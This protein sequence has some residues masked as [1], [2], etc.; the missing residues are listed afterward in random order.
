MRHV[1]FVLWFPVALLIFAFLTEALSAV[2]DS[3]GISDFQATS[4]LIFIVSAV[5][6]GELTLLLYQRL[7]K[8][9]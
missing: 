3:L 2:A 8:Q 5:L 4:I 1:L 9:K 6:I 7:F